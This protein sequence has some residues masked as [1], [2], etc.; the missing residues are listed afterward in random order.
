MRVQKVE[1]KRVKLNGDKKGIG[2]ILMMSSHGGP[3]R[4]WSVKCCYYIGKRWSGRPVCSCGVQ[5]TLYTRTEAS[6]L[7]QIAS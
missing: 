6:M 3:D 4:H 2:A 7:L 5:W 1:L